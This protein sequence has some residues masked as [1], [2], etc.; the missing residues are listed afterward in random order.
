MNFN[1]KSIFYTALILFSLIPVNR[2][3]P[4]KRTTTKRKLP[5]IVAGIR[6][7]AQAGR[8]KTAPFPTKI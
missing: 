4:L 3:K 7:K 8:Q 5:K 6:K 1:I 2:K